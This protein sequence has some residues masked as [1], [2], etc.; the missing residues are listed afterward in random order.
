MF[1]IAASHIDYRL[2]IRVD[3]RIDNRDGRESGLR[4]RG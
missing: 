2:T 3:S 1:M 4:E